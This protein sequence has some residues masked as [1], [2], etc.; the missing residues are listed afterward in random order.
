VVFF[1]TGAWHGA[2]WNFIV[3][4][5]WHGFFLWLERLDPVH[6]VLLRTPRLMRNGYVLFVVLVGWVMFRAESMEYATEF[7]RSMFGL[8]AA[9]PQSVSIS[10]VT[11]VPMLMVIV[12][13]AFLAYPVWPRAKAMWVSV[14]ERGNRPIIGDLARAAYVAAVMLLS[15]ATMAVGHQNPFLYFRF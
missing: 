10:Q 6:D 7:L 15:L 8:Q 11:S 13:A 9:T 5:L 14:T 1:L 2:S 12:M 4:G 3:W